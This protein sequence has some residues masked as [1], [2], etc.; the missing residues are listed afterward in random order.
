MGVGEEMAHNNNEVGMTRGAS[1][2]LCARQRD[3]RQNS[4]QTYRGRRNRA[5]TQ[6][7]VQE[8]HAPICCPVVAPW[9]SRASSP[10][11]AVATPVAL[12]LAR[13]WVKETTPSLS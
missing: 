1:S 10:L 12:M 6:Q 2:V 7:T 5:H 11:V 9:T 8:C 13:S 4:I 3:G